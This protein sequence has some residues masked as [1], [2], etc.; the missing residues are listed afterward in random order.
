MRVT[1][2]WLLV[3]PLASTAVTSLFPQAAALAVVMFALLVVLQPQRVVA[4]LCFHLDPAHRQLEAVEVLQSR[5][6]RDWDTVVTWLYPRVTLP[7][8]PL[9]ALLCQLE[10]LLPAAVAI[11]SCR[12]ALETAS[13]QMCMCLLV[14][15]LDHLARVVL[16][17]SLLVLVPRVAL[18]SSQVGAE[19][20]HAGGTLLWKRAAVCSARAHPF[21]F[22]RMLVSLLELPA[23]W[24]ALELLLLKV[25][26]PH[27]EEVFRLWVGRDRRVPCQLQLL[28]QLTVVMSTSELVLL[29]AEK[30][31]ALASL[32]ALALELVANWA[33]RVVMDFL[34]VRW[35]WPLDLVH[36]LLVVILLSTAVWVHL[37]CRQVATWL[38]NLL[39]DIHLAQWIL[40][41]V[42]LARCRRDRCWYPVETVLLAPPV[43]CWWLLV[44]VAPSWALVLLSRQAI[45]LLPMVWVEM[46]RLLLAL[47]QTEARWDW[48]AAKGLRVSVVPSASPLV[49]ALWPVGQWLFSLASLLVVCPAVRHRSTLVVAPKDRPVA[50]FF[51]QVALPTL[52]LAE[53]SLFPEALAPLEQA[54][55][56]AWHQLTLI[57]TLAW[58]KSP[59][60]P[61]SMTALET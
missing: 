7:A 54:V 35:S 37:P 61:L 46:W 18:L 1:L 39:L 24:I 47:V 52:H 13:D 8:L 9:D 50:T 45:Q 23:L 30:R 49:R 28:M 38:C 51:W 17:C 10:A 55:P 15:L 33:W 19:P 40:A 58:S 57:L 34:E 48:L 59:P 22:L 56:C 32:S 42:L 2:P 41:V 44:P 14:T 27:K 11:F 21:L 16:F 12:L 6:L 20:P 29:A 25:A 43:M 53:L 31:V 26:L 3:P 4:M 5:Q 60:G 36:L